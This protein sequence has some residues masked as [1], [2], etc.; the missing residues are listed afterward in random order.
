[1]VTYIVFLLLILSVQFC[2]LN[3]FSSITLTDSMI[4]SSVFVSCEREKQYSSVRQ[5]IL[6][7]CFQQGRHNWLYTNVRYPT[8]YSQCEQCMVLTSLI[9]IL[10]LPG[11]YIFLSLTFANLSLIRT[12][13]WVHSWGVFLSSSSPSFTNKMWQDNHLSMKTNNFTPWIFQILSTSSIFC[14]SLKI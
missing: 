10:W 12:F 8:I 11:I 13:Q 9:V 2:V 3:S 6:H 5:Q 14:H 1:M 4:I 7:K